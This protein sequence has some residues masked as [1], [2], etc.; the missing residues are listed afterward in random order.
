[1]RGVRWSDRSR[2]WAAL[3]LAVL[4]WVAVSCGA[5]TIDGDSAASQILAQLNELAQ[6]NEADGHEITAVDC[7]DDVQVAAES[8]FD[9]TATEP[10]GAT[11]TI[12]VTQ[13]DDDG[14]LDYRIEPPA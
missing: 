7:P 8:T 9:C 13:L 2:S 10:D 5:P 6:R 4:A 14:T 3:P 11:W 12:E 1:V